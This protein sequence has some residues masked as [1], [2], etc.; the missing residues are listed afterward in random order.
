M[1]G[2]THGNPIHDHHEEHVNNNN[3]SSNNNNNGDEDDDDF[4]TLTPVQTSYP[5]CRHCNRQGYYGFYPPERQVATPKPFEAG[6][7][8][9]EWMVD[10]EEIARANRWND[11]AKLEVLPV[12]LK[13]KSAKEW[14]RQHQ[15]ECWPSTLDMEET[16][17][18]NSSIPK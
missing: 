2:P 16:L 3:S 15:D 12:F 5:P 10:F 7:D 8:C 17:R 9:D 1:N 6:D 14:F 11:Q 18:I 13:T 4:I